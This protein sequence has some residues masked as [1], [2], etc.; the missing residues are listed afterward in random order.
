MI[1]LTK[2]FVPY[3]Q[4]DLNTILNVTAAIDNLNLVDSNCGIYLPQAGN[5]AVLGVL[6]FSSVGSTNMG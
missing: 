4:F 5:E 2:T 6:M 1:V 3:Q